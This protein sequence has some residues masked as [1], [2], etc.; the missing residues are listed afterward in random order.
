[1]YDDNFIITSKGSIHEISGERAEQAKSMKWYDNTGGY[2]FAIVE[3]NTKS[4][5][6][7]LMDAPKGMVV[8][9]INGNV[10]DSR[11][12]NLR[13][14]THYQNLKNRQMNKNNSS[15]VRGVTWCKRNKRW[16]AKI[17]DRGRGFNLGYFKT[18]EEAS[19]AYEA[20]YKELAGEFYREKVA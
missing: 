14:C 4:L 10:K 1:M 9:H 17:Q 20:K 18:I 13:I 2:C 19:Q 5:H 11:V 7:F 16:Y 6:R 8:D 3:G 15:G 12:E